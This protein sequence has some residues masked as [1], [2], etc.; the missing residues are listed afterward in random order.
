M[1]GQ[2]Q[3]NDIRV[4]FHINTRST[5]DKRR[6]DKWPELAL[7]LSKEYKVKVIDFTG[8]RGDF[9]YI[10]SVQDTIPD[11]I[12]TRNLA[13]LTTLWQLRY[14]LEGCDLFVSV[15]TFAMHLGVCLGIPMVAIVGATHPSVILPMTVHSVYSEYAKDIPLTDVTV[16]IGETSRKEWKE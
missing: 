11:S 9:Q 14:H 13:G 16:A 4:V 6:W 5:Q 1:G 3:G 8:T 2:R 12:P 7:W 15:N 10:R